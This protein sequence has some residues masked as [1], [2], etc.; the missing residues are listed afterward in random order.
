M[1]YKKAIKLIEENVLLIFIISL[2]A[3]L[4]FYQLSEIAIFTFD[5]EHQFTIAQTIVKDFHLIWI[6]TSA[7]NLGFY[8]G[9]FWVY[10]NALWLKISADPALTFYIGA[11]IGV[12]TTF[13]IW[14]VAKKLFDRKAAFVAALLYATLPLIVYHNQKFWN[15][16]TIPLLAVIMIF[17]IYSSLRNPRWWVLFFAVFGLIFHTHL[18]LVPL[19][20]VGVFFFLKQKFSINCKIFLLPVLT[21]FIVVS[22]LIVFDYFHNWSNI[23]APLRINQVSSSDTSKIGNHLETFINTW[24]RIWYLKP[25]L[26]SEDEIPFACGQIFN[27]EFPNYDFISIRTNPPIWLS[28]ISALILFYFLLKPS[29]WKNFN[30]RILALGLVSVIGPFILFPGGAFEYYLLGSFPLYL[31]AVGILISRLP[32]QYF[33]FGLLPILVVCGLGAFTVM[34]I[35]KEFGLG[36]KK[37]LINQVMETV[38]EE[39]FELINNGVCHRYDGWR[40]LFTVYGRTPERSDT[41]E[42]LGWL[43][44]EEI[45]ETKVNLKVIMSERKILP[46]EDISK[47]N[48]IEGGGFKA[49]IIG[50]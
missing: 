39:P 15:V 27:K 2:A 5:E 46:T 45:T 10:F 33:I 28:I 25:G 19:G 8:H 11:F 40:Y 43:Y 37:Q 44:P 24:G 13:L 31:L 14:V 9:P 35:N 48:I 3:F 16:N 38:G 17:F 50:K 26:S 18:S 29:T 6:G 1:N 32:K 30:T 34:N 22:P 21:F 49:Y 42:S 23:T 41:D 36:V 12:V 7:T 47:A 4:R 20:L